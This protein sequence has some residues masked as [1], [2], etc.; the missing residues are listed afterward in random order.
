M[1]PKKI[2]KIFYVIMIL[3]ISGIA[4]SGLTLLI[5]KERIIEMVKSEVDQ[6]IKTELS[7]EA[8]DIILLK[9]FPNIPVQFAGVKFHSAF[10]GELLLE[11]EYIYFVVN[12]VDLFYNIITIE[13]LE[14]ENATLSIHKDSNGNNNFDVFKVQESLTTSDGI[15]DIRSAKF[16]NVE[17]V[18]IDEVRNIDDRYKIDNLLGSIVLTDAIYKFKVKTKAVL[19]NTSKAHLGWLKG[20]QIYL[21]TISTYNKDEVINFELSEIKIDNSNFKFSGFLELDSDNKVSINLKGESLI[22]SELSTL[23][24]QKIRQRTELF[25]THGMIKFDASL[26]GNFA[27]NNWPRF[28]ANFTFKDFEI[29]H[30]G[31]RFPM[32]EISLDGKIF[33]DDLRKLESVKLEISNFK[34]SVNNRVINVKGSI[35]NFEKPQI[36]AKV[37]G[38][39]DAE[40][41][42]SL[43]LEDAQNK[44]GVSTG[45]LSV[46]LTTS[47]SVENEM[48]KVVLRE[49]LFDGKIGLDNV[50]IESIF[51]LPIRDVT[52]TASF[53]NDKVKLQDLEGFYGQSDFSI[54]GYVLLS[55]TNQ[56]SIIDGIESKINIVSNKIELEE[57]VKAIVSEP[58][59]SS[60]ITSPKPQ[61]TID[62]GLIVKE[63]N[64]RR[65][66]GKNFKAQA[67]V[68][69]DGVKIRRAISN[70]LGGTIALAG[71]ITKQFNEDYYI[72][73]KTKTKSVELDSLFYVF[74]DFNQNFITASVVKG[75]LESE[76]YTHMYFNRDWS[77][78]RN[79]LYAEGLF[80]VKNGQLNKFEPIMSLSGY[81][82]NEEE[83]LAKL[84]FSDLESSITIANDTVYISDMYIG[85]NVRNIKVGGY[86]TL[87]Q[88]I[89]YRLSVPVSGKN[90]DKDEDFGE[91]KQSKDG[92]LYIP[93]RIK[94][95]TANYEVNYDLKRARSNI[96]KGVKGELSGIGK[97]LVDKSEIKNKGDTL[98]LDDD[99][100]FDWDN[101]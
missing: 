14:I 26:K 32:K 56:T 73:A 30:S 40:W 45:M 22:F 66:H 91:I 64:F 24:P 94:G 21:N 17:I 75:E 48:N 13:R 81:L 37:I 3:I 98:L 35:N 95:T 59:E 99:E 51:N 54:N 1:S 57:L 82:K 58:L 38:D 87:D 49:P 28:F 8:I 16:L 6:R 41:L 96:V 19:T 90:R 88:A 71:S 97:S 2:R 67:L 5:Y 63:I 65:L 92:K 12:V 62:L 89:D 34:A 25:D 86:H 61:F 55:G 79:L 70:G 53:T 77:L 23:F 20:R 27:N 39:I 43:A 100:F 42:M 69:Q 15:L 33:I 9:G 47:F 29:S 85:S 83:N 4:I 80:K 50:G 18:H 11:S 52:G 72:E 84:R 44:Y 36:K 10:K 68:N 101:K 31:P 74:D 76:V 78:H 46:D 60:I 93:F 7:V